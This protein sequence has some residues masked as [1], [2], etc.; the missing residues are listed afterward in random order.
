MTPMCELCKIPDKSYNAEQGM[1]LQLYTMSTFPIYPVKIL[2]TQ[3]KLKAL[4][5]RLK[6][7]PEVRRTQTLL[8]D[9]RAGILTMKFR[10]EFLARLTEESLETIA[11]MQSDWNHRISRIKGLSWQVS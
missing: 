2:S 4:N 11:S 1:I 6:V 7:K 8:Y 10:Q 9:D 5:C 3:F